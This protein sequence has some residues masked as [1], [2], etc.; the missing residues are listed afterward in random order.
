MAYISPGVEF[1]AFGSLIVLGEDWIC[2]KQ[3]RKI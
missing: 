1:K 2:E 3:H